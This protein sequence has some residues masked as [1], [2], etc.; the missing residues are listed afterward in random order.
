MPLLHPILLNN[1]RRS[2]EV[3]S[4]Y[5]L[6][7][8]KQ[9]IDYSDSKNKIIVGLKTNLLSD[10]K[11]RYKYDEVDD[12]IHFFNDKG[13]HFGTLFD[14]GSRYQELRHNGK[15]NDKGWLK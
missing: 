4:N 1:F 3:N 15:L 11:D 10:M 8:E 7:E 6:N 14:K 13:E 12:K 5:L 2:F 9:K